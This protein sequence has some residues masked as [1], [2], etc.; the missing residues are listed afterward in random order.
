MPNFNFSIFFFYILKDYLFLTQENCPWLLHNLHWKKYIYSIYLYMINNFNLIFF[1]F[2]LHYD[3]PLLYQLQSVQYRTLT[4][5]V[6][7]APCEAK[8]AARGTTAAGGSSTVHL[9]RS[10]C[11]NGAT[12]AVL[13]KPAASPQLPAMTPNWEGISETVWALPST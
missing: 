13:L 7:R 12:S 9:A 1:F 10:P 4:A 6:A 2:F 8:A 5:G 11:W 3:L